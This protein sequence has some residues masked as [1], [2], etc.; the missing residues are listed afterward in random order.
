MC[1]LAGFYL[2]NTNKCRRKFDE[3]GLVLAGGKWFA[4]SSCLWASPFSISEFKVIGTL[5]PDLERFF[6]KELHVKTASVSM[7][8]REL[9]SLAKKQHPPV[10]KMRQMLIDIGTTVARNGVDDKL[11]KA[12]EGLKKVQFLS[13][14]ALSNTSAFAG[15]DDD[16]VIPDHARFETAFQGHLPVLDLSLD[17]SQILDSLF[18]HLGLVDRYLSSAVKEASVVNEAALEDRALSQRLRARAYALFW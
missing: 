3:P 15:I 13:I 5:Y 2:E 17:E 16:F 18:R 12:L 9:T 14:K 6:V 10:G 4:S 7:L 11:S 1:K 8:V